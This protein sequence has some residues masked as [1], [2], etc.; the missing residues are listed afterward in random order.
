MRRLLSITALALFLSVPLCAQR[1]G[2]GGGFAG[3]ASF[4]A[5]HGGAQFGGHAGGFAGHAP[6][7]GH[8]GGP[9]YGGMRSGYS[10]GPARAY[11]RGYSRAP[12]LH[13]SSH[14]AFHN[15]SHGHFHDHGFRRNCYAYG[16]WGGYGYGYPAWGAY[17]D[18]FAWDWNYDDA[19]FDADYNNNL[20]L[21]NQMNEQSLEQQRMLRQEEA[22]RDQDLYG[23]D[24]SRPS[25]KQSPANAQSTPITP[26][27]VL[28]F[29]DHHQ[30]EI[31]NYA[32]IGQTLWIFGAP[33]NQKVPL[34]DLDLAATQKANDDR[35]VTF[36]PPSVSVG[37]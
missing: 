23:P 11:N 15:G 32:I 24:A 37:Q 27:T 4:G 7:A 1:G 21:A 2:H 5:G 33:H 16:C 35:G 8:I 31:Q 9:F 18:P 26:P 22:D 25:S 19:R 14:S 12:Y 28:I 6:S 34:S 36:Q 13:N 10:R 3:H 20:A 29:R 30:Q 17:Y